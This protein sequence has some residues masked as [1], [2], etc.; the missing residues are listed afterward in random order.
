MKAE[1]KEEEEEE[2]KGDGM[3]WDGMEMGIRLGWGYSNT[4]Y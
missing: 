3:G 4:T 2:E 1:E